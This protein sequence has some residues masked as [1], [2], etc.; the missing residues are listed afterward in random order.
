[1]CLIVTQG[2]PELT[3]GPESPMLTSQDTQ[4]PSPSV[5]INGSVNSPGILPVSS[6]SPNTPTSVVKS[7]KKSSRLATLSRLFKPWKWKKRKKASEKIEKSAVG[8]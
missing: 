4:N 1:M 3:N 7:E 8:E 6:S 5:V 2:D